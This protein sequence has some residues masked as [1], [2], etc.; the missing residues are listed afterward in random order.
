MRSL[1]DMLDSI[2][3]KLASRV[4]VM[5]AV[6]LACVGC[7][8]NLDVDGALIPAWLI[9]ALLGLVMAI[10]ARVALVRLGLDRHLLVRPLVYVSLTILFACAAWLMFFRY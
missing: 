3:R 2:T 8:P 10:V 4:V 1:S 9:A 5:S 6:A 7:N